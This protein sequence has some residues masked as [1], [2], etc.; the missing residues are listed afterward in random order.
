MGEEAKLEKKACDYARN[1][2]CYVRKFSSPS[3]RGVPDRLFITPGGVVFF[4]EFKAFGKKPTALQ[5]RESR[6]ILQHGVSA[7]CVDDYDKAVHVI[8]FCIAKT[9]KKQ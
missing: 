5:L 8:D 3:N 2:G 1:K 4:I 6:E 9:L 7:F